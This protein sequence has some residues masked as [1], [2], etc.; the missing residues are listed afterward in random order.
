[1][2]ARAAA[3]RPSPSGDL[4]GQLL[5]ATPLMPD[6]TFM[7]TVI[8][9]VR[10]DGGGAMG[11]VLNRPMVEIPLARLLEQLGIESKEASGTIRTHYGGPVERTRGFVLHTADYV[12]KSTLLIKDGVGMTWQ[13][14]IWRVIASGAGPRRRLF[15]LGHS[16]W[17]PGQLEAE[18]GAGHWVAVPADEA[19]VFDEDYDGKWP[20]AMARRRLTL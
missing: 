1:M 4:T 18:M 19:L 14:E 2:G 16:G 12:G 10:H 5:V 11:L 8:Y 9:M 17:A 3:Q 7:R 6:P 13:P 15:V 20:R